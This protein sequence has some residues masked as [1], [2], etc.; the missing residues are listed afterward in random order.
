[1]SVA[2]QQPVSWSPPGDAG[3]EPAT[4]VLDVSA[5]ELVTALAMWDARVPTA[6]L[7]A[8]GVVTVVNRPAFQ[9]GIRLGM[10]RETVFARGVHVR[11]TDAFD[12]VEAAEA[13]LRSWLAP[14]DP[15]VAVTGAHGARIGLSG[16]AGL[17]VPHRAAQRIRSLLAERIVGAVSIGIGPN[18]LVAAMASR[19]ITDGIETVRAEAFSSTFGSEPVQALIGVSN[20]TSRRLAGLGV[21]TISQLARVRV[22][23]LNAAF[24]AVGHVLLAR[25]RGMDDTPVVSHSVSAIVPRR[26]STSPD[27]DT[28]GFLLDVSPSA[29]I[30]TGSRQLRVL[31]S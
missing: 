3:H 16:S 13:R 27:E 23:R 11:D 10:D 29:A 19:R 5:P 4:V 25:A 12:S 14:L 18:A 22:D 7:S 8:E 15:V 28:H 1:M 20:A 6:G 26:W 21:F 30:D 24:G 9:A 17:H 2:Y 31:S